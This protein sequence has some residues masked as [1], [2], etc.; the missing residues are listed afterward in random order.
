MAATTAA[1]LVEKMEFFVAVQSV[2]LTVALR[3]ASSAGILGGALV[4]K[5]VPWM[6]VTVPAMLVGWKVG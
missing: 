3:A 2:V 5:M 1:S 4:A 6:A